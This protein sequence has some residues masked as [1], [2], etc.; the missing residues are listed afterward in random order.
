VFTL[1]QILLSQEEGTVH[2]AVVVRH[3]R[4]RWRGNFLRRYFN[5]NRGA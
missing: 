1:R 4:S 3:E 2:L 5:T